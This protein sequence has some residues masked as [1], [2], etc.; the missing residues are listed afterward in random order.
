MTRDEILTIAIENEYSYDKTQEL[1]EE[2]EYKRLYS[3]LRRDSIVIWAL[4][5]SK[6]KECVENLFDQYG[7]KRFDM[8]FDNE[9][10]SS[11]TGRN[12]PDKVIKSKH[13]Q[14]TTK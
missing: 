3:R 11:S 6:D 1:L 10:V 9:K 5:H 8:S 7:C 2:Y 4:F 12:E 14:E 13:K